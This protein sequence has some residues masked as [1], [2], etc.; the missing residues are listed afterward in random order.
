MLLMIGIDR[1]Q[2]QALVNPAVNI[3]HPFFCSYWLCGSI[4]SEMSLLC[5]VIQKTISLFLLLFNL[6]C[7]LSH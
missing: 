2:C 1:D 4:K 7:L 6:N 5:F 3:Q